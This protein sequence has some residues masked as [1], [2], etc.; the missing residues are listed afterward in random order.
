MRKRDVSKDTES[1]PGQQLP[2]RLGKVQ[3]TGTTTVQAGPRA[4]HRPPPPRWGP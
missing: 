4:D 3:Y 2:L 1:A